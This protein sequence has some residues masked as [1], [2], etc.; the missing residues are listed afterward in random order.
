M[1]RSGVTFQMLAGTTRQLYVDRELARIN[2]MD[3]KQ[4]VVRTPLNCL[5]IR[6][7]GGPDGTTYTRAKHVEILGPSRF[8]CRLDAPLEPTGPVM[9]VETEAALDVTV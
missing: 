7:D 4:G 8:V 1:K 2:F 9:W 6:N 5:I 3:I